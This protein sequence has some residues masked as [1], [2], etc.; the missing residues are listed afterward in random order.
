L[1]LAVAA[2]LV[3]VVEVLVAAAA[4]VLAGIKQAHCLYLV[5]L[6]TQ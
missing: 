6:H 5:E 1:L 2:R 4:A 3:L